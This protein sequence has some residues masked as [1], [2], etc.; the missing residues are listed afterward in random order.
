M[1]APPLVFFMARPR[2][3]GKTER[4]LRAPRYPPSHASSVNVE[5]RSR[6]S[7]NRQAFAIGDFIQPSCLPRRENASL[8]L[9]SPRLPPLEGTRNTHQC[10]PADGLGLETRVK[11]GIVETRSRVSTIW[12]RQVTIPWTE[13]KKDSLKPYGARESLAIF[14]CRISSRRRDN[15]CLPPCH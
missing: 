12:R 6:V 13:H 1:Q 4:L 5:T 9:T 11:G 15:D 3:S 8:Q 7:A 2:S 10:L 14:V